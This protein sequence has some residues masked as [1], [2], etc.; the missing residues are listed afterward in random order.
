MRDLRPN[1]EGLVV[2]GEDAEDGLL[3][4]HCCSSHVCSTNYLRENFSKKLA[5]HA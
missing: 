1:I 4:R 3:H 5:T 2:D